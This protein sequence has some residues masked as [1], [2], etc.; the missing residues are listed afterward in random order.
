MTETEGKYSLVLEY[1][2]TRQTG[3]QV[4]HSDSVPT[5][6]SQS[7]NTVRSHESL[8]AEIL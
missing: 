8:F 4:L 6:S 2:V 7:K 5:G 3:M 1:R